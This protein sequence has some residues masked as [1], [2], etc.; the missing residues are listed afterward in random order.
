MAGLVPT[1]RAVTWLVRFQNSNDLVGSGLCYI[2][3][4]V[5]RLSAWMAG[6][7]PA[8]TEPV[9]FR[10]QTSHEGSLTVSDRGYKRPG[11]SAPVTYFLVI[12]IPSDAPISACA[13]ERA[14]PLQRLAGQLRG[15]FACGE[16]STER[17]GFSGV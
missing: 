1:T 3:E 2:L 13:V 12:T 7:S 4:P 5:L 6:T 15:E 17:R 11:V 16:L 8:M 14:E 10:G 9:R